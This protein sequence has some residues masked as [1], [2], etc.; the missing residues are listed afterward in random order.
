MH[1][2]IALIYGSIC[3]V[4]LINYSLTKETIRFAFE[5]SR[6]GSVSPSSNLSSDYTDYFGEKWKGLNELT[7]VGQRQQYILGYHTRLRYIE[8]NPLLSKSFDPREIYV[9][10][11]N[12]NCTI[13]SANAQLQGLY[14]PGTGATLNQRQIDN[15][16]PPNDILYYKKEREDLGTNALPDRMTLIPVHNF[17]LKDHSFELTDPDN[18]PDMA[19]YYKDKEKE[20]RDK[21]V[22]EFITKYGEKMATIIGQTDK[23]AFNDYKL[24]KSIVETLISEEYDGRTLNKIKEA[25]INVKELLADCHEYLSNDLLYFDAKINEL[26]SISMSPTIKDIV[27][28]I[29]LK[30]NNDLNGLYDSTDYSPPKFVLYLSYAPSLVAFQL[31][32]RNIWPDVTP[33]YPRFASSAFLELIQT[34]AQS[35]TSEKDYIIRYRFNNKQFTDVSYTAFIDKASTMLKSMDEIKQFCGWVDIK[36]TFNYYIIIITALGIV[37]ISLIT[38]M[39][40]ICIKRKKDRE[41]ALYTQTFK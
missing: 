25:G 31:F 11:T 18:C 9:T 20:Y 39:V 33:S 37:S 41:K 12:S 1:F 40:F 21:W 19:N 5:L 26:A 7:L 10:S 24:T 27:E 23:N 13:L 36:P 16:N 30:V 34:V 29:K 28:W 35:P 4:V 2:N 32:I 14:P 22:N 3:F 6:H 8:D 38:M 15:A 17:H